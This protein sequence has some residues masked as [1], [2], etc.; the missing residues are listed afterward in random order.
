MDIESEYIEL[1]LQLALTVIAMSLILL[2]D[3]SRPFTYLYALGA[4]LL[5]GYTAVISED[6]FKKSSLGAGIGLVFMP[7]GL[8]T[9]VIAV[10][11]LACNILISVFASGGSFKDHYSATA[12]PLL[13]M[14]ILIGGS[15][16]A[17]A[18]YDAEF[19]SELESK[20]VE[21]GAEKTIR[22]IEI[23]G[24]GDGTDQQAVIEATNSTIFITQNYV[25]NDYSQKTGNSDI[26]ALQQSFEDAR[27]ELPQQVAEQSAESR[28]EEIRDRTEMMI[29]NTVSNRMPIAVFVFMVTTLYAL[30]PVLG[31]LTALFATAFVALRDFL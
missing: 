21:I 20:A 9:S 12:I 29:E 10:F 5:F 11:V 22:M 13:L 16:G 8:F 15:V 23:T 27:Q 4:P 6:N 1:G 25:V 2:I 31:L 18:Y 7:I 28:P 3:V 17:Y 30:Q 26:E 19:E 24:M 14:G